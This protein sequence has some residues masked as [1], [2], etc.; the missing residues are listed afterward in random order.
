[1]S[2]W[3]L[4]EG[5]F[6]LWHPLKGQC[7]EETPLL[8][9]KTHLFALYHHDD[10]TWL[11]FRPRFFFLF[12]SCKTALSSYCFAP[13]THQD[14]GMQEI[15]RKNPFFTLPLMYTRVKKI[16]L[17]QIWKPKIDWKNKIFCIFSLIPLYELIMESLASSQDHPQPLA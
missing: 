3:K 11:C 6:N 12:F 17:G 10:S 8:L 5:E 2:N 16:D 7:Q 14:Q 9:Q 1:M 4:S 13:G 15:S